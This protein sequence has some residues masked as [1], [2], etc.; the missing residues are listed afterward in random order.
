MIWQITV[1]GGENALQHTD[2][3]CE[4]GFCEAIASMIPSFTQLLDDENE[5]VWWRVIEVIG[6][7]ANHG[8]RE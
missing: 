4:V 5:D 3:E 8:Q 6:K 7:L 2:L 1:S